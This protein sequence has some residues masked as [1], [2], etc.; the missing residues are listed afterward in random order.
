MGMKRLGRRFWG[1]WRDIQRGIVTS[2]SAQIKAIDNVRRGI[3]HQSKAE[4]AK[5]REL[6]RYSER[7]R[8]MQFPVATG[9]R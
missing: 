6:H 3:W 9:G 1:F 2:D 8:V 5:R 7:A 4:R